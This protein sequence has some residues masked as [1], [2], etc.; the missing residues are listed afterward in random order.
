MSDYLLECVVWTFVATALGALAGWLVGILV[1]PFRIEPA[2]G[3]ARPART[4]PREQLDRWRQS[5]RGHGAH[6]RSPED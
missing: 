5:R 6:E 3:G 4:S 2:H 1:A